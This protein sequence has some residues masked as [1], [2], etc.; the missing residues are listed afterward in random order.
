MIIAIT[1][2]EAK[3][4]SAS[5]KLRTLKALMAKITK[6]KSVA[7][8]QVGTSGNHRPINIAAPKNSVPS[9]TVQ[10]IQYNHATVNPVP[11]L[12]NFVA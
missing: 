10:Q 12:M 6:A 2:I 4:D 9:A 5:A 3:K 7:K 8:I 1:L 11:G